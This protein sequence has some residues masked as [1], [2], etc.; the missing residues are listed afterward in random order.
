MKILFVTR[1]IAPPWNE[2]SKNTVV[3]LA[4][5]MKGHEVHLLTEKGFKFGGKHIVSEPI[6]S[7]SGLVS[8][9]SFKQKLKLMLRILK[10]DDID[11]YHFFFK[12]TPLVALAVKLA[13]LFNKKKLVQTVVSVPRQGEQISKSIFSENIVVGSK[14]MQNRLKEEGLDSTL[15]PF[16]VNLQ[17]LKPFDIGATKKSFGIAG[18]PTILFPGD[19]FTGK[20]LDI[21][22]EAMPAVLEKFHGAKFVLAC[23]F[24]GT[25]EEKENLWKA[26]K[27]IK[28]AGFSKNVVFLDE[29]PGLKEFVASSDLIIYPLGVMHYKMDYPLVLL[30]AMALGK[31]TIFSNVPPLNELSEPGSNVMIEKNNPQELANAINSILSDVDLRHELGSNARHLVETKFN[32]ADSVEKYLEFYEKVLGDSK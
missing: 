12:P 7:E 23:R 21:V 8:G 15:I 14:F 2:G 22:V 16:G 18:S 26:K 27:R 24:L 9:R 4:K 28:E 11:I 32:L 17:N 1:P 20:G 29:V 5:G 25:R 3:E 30:E 10:R 19:L 31:A 13:I 6:F